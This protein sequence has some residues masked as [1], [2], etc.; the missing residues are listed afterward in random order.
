[1]RTL[2]SVLLGCAAVIASASSAGA[3]LVI[4]SAPTSNVTCGAGVCSATAA[5][6]VLNA[7]DLAT[8]LA[9]GNVNVESGSDA[10]DIDVTAPL[11][12]STRR[13]LTLTANGSI[14]VNAT[15]AAQGTG[16][17]VVLVTG[18]GGDLTFTAAAWISG[19]PT[20]I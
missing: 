3:A 17:R 13:T 12:W 5:N 16:A 7:G 20:A 4:S 18:S 9:Q 2:S 8:A 10:I 6:A 14:A 1:M 11:A 19:A 15:V